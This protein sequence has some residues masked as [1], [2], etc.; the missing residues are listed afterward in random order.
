MK[1]ASTNQALT[2][3]YDLGDVLAASAGDLIKDIGQG[4]IV[5]TAAV[6]ETLRMM[7]NGHPAVRYFTENGSVASREVHLFYI[8]PPAGSVA[9]GAKVN[10]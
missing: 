9:A 7:E 4:K 10:G 8:P 5:S 2:E 3:E 1:A 6:K